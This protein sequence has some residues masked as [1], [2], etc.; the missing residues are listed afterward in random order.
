MF[1][2]NIGQTIVP[3]DR[4]LAVAQGYCH[5][6]KA[7]EGVFVGVSAS[8]SPQVR[9]KFRVFGYWNAEGKNVGWRGSKT[10]DV[11]TGNREVERVTTLHAKRVYKLA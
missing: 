1:T 8:G 5:S 11:E 4:V 9:C 10:Q 3:G 2:N 6:I 7:R